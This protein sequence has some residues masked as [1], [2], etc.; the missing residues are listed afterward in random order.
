LH[1]AHA[2]GAVS[3]N[4]DP[5]YYGL[6]LVNMLLLLLLLLLCMLMALSAVGWTPSATVSPWS[7][8]CCLL[9]LNTSIVNGVCFA[10]DTGDRG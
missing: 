4:L 9:D 3:C 10:T 2:D 5:F 7:T 1:F 8:C 6:T